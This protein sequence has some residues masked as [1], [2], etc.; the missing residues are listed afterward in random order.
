[1]FRLIAYFGGIVL[2]TVALSWLA[3]RPGTLVLE[4]QNLEI[5]TSVFRAVVMAA[6]AGAALIVLWSL[7]KHI[8]TSPQSAAQFVRRR[9]QK[10]GIEALTSG[11]IAVSSGDRALASR[12]TQLARKSLPNEP[13][14]LLLRAQTAELMGDR[15]TA[16]RIY[17]AMR[18]TP[19]TELLGLRGLFLEAKREGEDEAARQ[20]AERALAINPRLG[21]SAQSLFELQCREQNWEGALETI[22]VM[23]RHGHIDKGL[24]DRRRGVLLTAQAM[25]MEEGDSARSLALALEAHALAPDLVP[26]AAIAGRLL[27][28]QGATGKAAKVL[29]KT[30]KK[31]PHPDLA[32]AYAFARIGDSPRDRLQRVR[33]LA[34]MTPNSDEGPMAVASQAIDAQDWDLARRVLAHLVDDR[35]SQRVCTLMARIEGGQNGDAGRVREWL[36]RAVH[37][38]RDPVWIADGHIAQRWAPI[39]PLT[40]ELDAFEWRVPEEQLES[41]ESALLVEELALGAKSQQRALE[42]AAKDAAAVQPARVSE[43]LS[44]QAADIEPEPV[45]PAE[46]V[47]SSA[48]A[49]H[50]KPVPAVAEER[51]Q[52]KRAE[53]GVAEVVPAEAVRPATNVRFKA[54][55][56]PTNGSHAARNG[57]K[58]AAVISPHAPDDPGPDVEEDDRVTR[59]RGPG[60]KRQA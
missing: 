40:G 6:I 36:A 26:A 57:V 31:S 58:E 53:P 37:A 49:A 33:D 38:P 13:L 51:A 1:M 17:E 15:A 9:R 35:P 20:F 11:M 23:R 34:R 18:N 45:Q 48:P 32:T 29:Q 5:R 24:A 46:S 50:P 59:F 56:G 30:W 3:D 43:P 4:W 7:L 44:R 28:S 60:G 21:W 52:A 25:E 14:T 2:L 55:A 12:Y 19:D 54:A 27:A 22:G 16:R 8:L 39:S 47:T 10:R 42:L 41:R